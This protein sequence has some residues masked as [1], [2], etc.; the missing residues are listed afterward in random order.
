MHSSPKILL[1]AI[2][3]SSMSLLDFRVKEVEEV[4]IFRRD[5]WI[6]HNVNIPPDQRYVQS[7]CE[8]NKKKAHVI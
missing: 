4:T 8:S 3:T 7:V 2:S 5:W 1:F 6:M